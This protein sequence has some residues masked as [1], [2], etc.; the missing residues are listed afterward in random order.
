MFLEFFAAGNIILTDNEYKI[1]GLFRIVPAGADLEEVKI[2][3]KY[4]VE[5]KQNFHGVP[6]L[7]VER[8][9]ETV[10]KAT[11]EDPAQENAAAGKKGKKKQ[12]DRLRRLLY[13]DF[14]EFPTLLLEHALHSTG[15]DTSVPAE[16]ILEDDAQI[17]K[18]MSALR[19]A[20]GLQSQLDN[21][22]AIRGYIMARTERL[23]Q[24]APPEADVQPRRK[25]YDFHPFVPKQLEDLPDTT[26]IPFDNFNKAV[27]EFF[28]SVEAQKLESRHTERESTA[29]RKLDAA[30]RDQEKRVGA[31]KQ[32]QE[33]HTTKAQRIEGNLAKVEEAMNAVNALIAQGM[34]WVEIARLIEM[35]QGKGNPVAKL[36]KLPLKLY[37]NTITLLLPEPV[38]DED[39]SESEEEDD[40][41]ES[42]GDGTQTRPRQDNKALGIDVD[43]GITA[44]ANARQYYDQKKTAA[45]K[46][47]KTLKASTKALKSAEKKIAADLKRGIKQ[48][49]PV[50]RPARTPFW[51]EKFFFFISSEGYLVIG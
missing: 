32:A 33:L 41:S 4:A 45:V 7:S 30:R 11:I 23:L 27:D 44:W 1:I 29:K 6:P 42:D 25:Y 26:I 19:V 36:I 48:E 8:L 3:L 22:D 35:E 14:P 47:E 13:Q 12:I 10:T 38:S 28:S 16:R 34:D 18:L 40:D 51:F 21:L 49:K 20:E 43:L 46:E 37:E 31:L 24:D 15:F 9:R 5:T 39:Q 50:L 17:T 2:G